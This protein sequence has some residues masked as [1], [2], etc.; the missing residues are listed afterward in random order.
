MVSYLCMDIDSG[1][2]RGDVARR[3]EMKRRFDWSFFKQFELTPEE[4]EARRPR[5]LDFE[6]VSLD[7]RVN[8]DKHLLRLKGRH[9]RIDER[10]RAEGRLDDEIPS[11]AVFE[12][13]LVNVIREADWFDGILFR[14]TEHD[15]RYNG[16][17]AVMEWPSLEPGEKPV[18]LAIDF[19]VSSNIGTLEEKLQSIDGMAKLKY[20]RSALEKDEAGKPL[21]TRTFFPKVILGADLDMLKEVARSGEMPDHNHPLRRILLA[22][23][24]RQIDIQIRRASNHYLNQAW[25]EEYP[26]PEV[27]KLC[28]K[29]RLA[30]T[31]EAVAEALSAAPEEAYKK[32]FTEDNKLYINACLRLKARLDPIVK[33]AE[34]IP[35]QEP[36]N[37][38]A[39]ISTNNRILNTDMRA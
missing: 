2:H 12:E 36:W 25:R 33:Q 35:L 6:H 18:R 15:D 22:Q 4:S 39:Q 11:G 37:T 10:L 14:T 20:F 26:H 9:G 5:A 21:E 8:A 19:S 32:L 13:F 30:P 34:Q 38:L 23:A 24:K 28:Q 29:I 1:R 17:D 16:V 3:P 27:D 31:I 7:D